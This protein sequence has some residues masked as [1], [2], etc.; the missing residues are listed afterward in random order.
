MPPQKHVLGPTHA[1]MLQ[2]EVVF[3]QS[4]ASMW[5]SA[6][7]DE[8]LGD[9]SV[10]SPS[11]DQPQLY[12]LRRK[13][14]HTIVGEAMRCAR[15]TVDS[16]NLPYDPG[17]FQQA[18]TPASGSALPVVLC[19]MDC[20]ADCIDND[21]DFGQ[22]HL[23]KKKAKAGK[24]AD[25][26]AEAPTASKVTKTGN[27]QGSVRALATHVDPAAPATPAPATLGKEQPRYANTSP[28]QETPLRK[29]NEGSSTW[30]EEAV[31]DRIEKAMSASKEAP[32]GIEQSFELFGASY[33]PQ[34]AR[35]TV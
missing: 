1:G 2:E 24:A 15:D 11:P 32:G 10:M 8:R 35:I 14:A 25:D 31:S 21:T 12:E 6:W 20:V 26:K 28:L 23:K 33:P 34:F 13:E 3:D 9:A 29:L 18:S 30:L 19:S 17:W 7:S 5:L 22:L 27:A 4:A 16:E